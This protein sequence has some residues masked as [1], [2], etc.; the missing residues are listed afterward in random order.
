MIECITEGNKRRKEANPELYKQRHREYMRKYNE[1]KKLEKL[2][3]EKS[4]ESE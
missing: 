4:C 3:K 1:K 2:E